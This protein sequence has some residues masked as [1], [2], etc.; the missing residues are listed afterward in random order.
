MVV[1]ATLREQCHEHVTE[2]GAKIILTGSNRDELRD[3]LSGP[4][5]GRHID[6]QSLSDLKGEDIALG[7]RYDA[8]CM[9]D[10]YKT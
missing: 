10:R 3:G 2:D 7:S 4:N 9:C 5:R 8:E 1:S 6:S